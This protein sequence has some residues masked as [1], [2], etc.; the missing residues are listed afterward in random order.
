MH[1]GKRNIDILITCYVIPL[2]NNRAVEVLGSYGPSHHD[3]RGIRMSPIN[4]FSRAERIDYAI[5]TSHTAYIELFLGIADASQIQCG[6][7]ENCR[8]RYGDWGDIGSGHLGPGT[9]S[10]SAHHRAE[11]DQQGARDSIVH[12]TFSELW[13][14]MG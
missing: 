14:L 5:S 4:H 2:N 6:S 8:S 9:K 3:A 1:C 10:K 13:G 12:S 7:A 11:C